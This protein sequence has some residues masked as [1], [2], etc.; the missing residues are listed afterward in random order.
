MKN[1]L[2]SKRIVFVYSLIVIVPIFVIILSITYTDMK[3]EGNRLKLEELTS[4]IEKCKIVEDAK[5]NFDLVESIIQGDADLS[6]FLARPESCSEDE[7]INTLLRKAD[8]L[9]KVCEI[10]PKIYSIRIFSNNP[11]IP[12]RWPVFLS[13]NRIINEEKERWSFD[14]KAMYLGNQNALQFPSFCTTRKIT[15]GPKEIGYIQITYRMESVFPFLFETETDRYSYILVKKSEIQKLAESPRGTHQNVELIKESPQ[16]QHLKI[17]DR[18]FK[19]LS[20]I[21]YRNLTED[22]RKDGFV[23]F[24]S[25]KN[26]VCYHY[27]SDADFFII[28]NISLKDIQNRFISVFVIVFFLF[29]FVSVGIFFIIKY[30]TSKIMSG[31]Y[32]VMDGMKQVKEGNLSVQIPVTGN[33]EVGETQTIFN[34][35]TQQL[36]S[37]IEQIKAEQSL[38]ADTE[39]KAMQNQINAHF[40]YNVLETIRMQAVL[41]DQ[42]EIADSIQILGRMMR[43]CLR[44]RVHRVSLSQEIDYIRSYIYILN[45]RNDYVITLDINIDENLMDIEIPKMTLQPLIE[46]AFVHAIEIEEK[47]ASLRVFS[48]LSEDKSRVI[49]SVQDFGCGMSPEQVDEIER[50]LQADGY[51][52]DSKGSIGLKNIQQRLTVFYGADYRIKIKSKVGEG[53]TISVPIPFKEIEKGESEN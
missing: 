9:E 22:R 25:L 19:T 21:L 29:L 23:S 40:L 37:Q 13:S 51:E 17:S 46:N 33:D 4:L 52:R 45:I 36:S 30:A 42:D 27:C 14:Y 15:K 49:L 8:F 35:M 16:Y 7:L 26:F 3:R 2:F 31:V 48:E 6:L 50:Y 53:T 10:T 44:W 34:S 20:K 5:N 12:E 28:K 47:D 11:K 24:G 1:M 43:Y 18:Q 38:I 41:A 39:M 32:S